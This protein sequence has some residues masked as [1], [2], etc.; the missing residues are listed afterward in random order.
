MVKKLCIFIFLF[1]V[2]LNS[3][4]ITPE[5]TV[6][7]F[8]LHGVV[9]NINYLE[10]TK[11]IL[12][13]LKNYQALK[14]LLNPI[15]MYK[16]FKLVKNCYV[17]EKVIDDFGLQHPAISNIKDSI[18]N[19][20]NCQKINSE[21]VETIKLLRH[22]GYKIYI[23]SN[24]GSKT[25]SEFVKKNPDFLSL[26]DGHFIPSQENGFAHKPHPEF[27][28]LFREK[29]DL[30]GVKIVFVDDILEN[31]K[32]AEKEKFDSI[33]FIN[34]EQCIAI[35]GNLLPNLIRY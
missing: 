1:F 8:D 4:K 30:E 22:L 2:N 7:A 31:V 6:F 20:I 14:F 15:I 17:I 11:T 3:E 33:L 21:M 28:K 32:A 19:I 35:L 27:Y 24:I 10:A 13:N 34:N 18:I 9:L 29:F 25:L 12:C 5:N 16:F 26:F 23:L